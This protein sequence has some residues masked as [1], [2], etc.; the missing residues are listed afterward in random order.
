MVMS[1]L[2]Q[3]L[4]FKKQEKTTENTLKE[5]QETSDAITS[6]E[7]KMRKDFWLNIKVHLLG[8]PKLNCKTLFQLTVSWIIFPISLASEVI[9]KVS[10]KE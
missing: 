3:Q 1:S 7:K 6:Q 10:W 9:K 4:K 2:N 5:I 8:L